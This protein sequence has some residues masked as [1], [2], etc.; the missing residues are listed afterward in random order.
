M[1]QWREVLCLFKNQRAIRKTPA[2]DVPRIRGRIV[3]LAILGMII[4]G[5]QLTLGQKAS[6]SN[7]ASVAEN[8]G[9][10]PLSFETNQGQSGPQV[11]FLSHGVGY[12]VFLT[13]SSATLA[14]TEQDVS[15]AKLDQAPEDGRKS[16]SV[17]KA[18]KIDV[19]QM[20]LAG[21]SHDAHAVGIDQLPGTAN[22]FVGSDPT[23]WHRN[24]PTYSKVKYTDVYPGVDLIYYGNR[25]QLEYDFVIKPGANPQSIRLHFSGL[26]NLKLTPN[27]DLA[28]S[29][30]N[31]EIVFHRPVIYQVKN[32]N[33]QPIEGRFSLLAKQSVGF[34]LGHYDHTKSLVIDPV[35]VY[36]TY[37]GGGASAAAIAVDSA[38]NAYVTG[39]TY[40]ASPNFPTTTGSFQTKSAFGYNAFV[41]KLNSSGTALLYS[42]YLG[43]SSDDSGAGIAVD[44]AGNAY[45]TGVATSRDF[46]V[47]TGAFQP[48]NNGITYETSGS[49]VIYSVPN[50]FITKLDPTGS[51]LIYSTY[52]GGNGVQFPNRLASPPGGT[53]PPYAYQGD[54]ASGIAVDSSGFAYVT[55]Q[56]VSTDFPVTGGAFQTKNNSPGYVAVPGYDTLPTNVF[57][58]KLNQTGTA[59]V[60][61]TY[62]GGTGDADDS[63]GDLGSGIAVDSSDS[64][65]VTGLTASSDYPVTVGAFQITTRNKSGSNA[66]I[67]KLNSMGTALTYSTYLGGSEESVGSSIAVDDSGD[68]Y[69]TGTTE[70]NDFPITPD[71][72]QATKKTSAAGAQYDPP[73]GFVTKLNSTG[74]ELVYST[75][76][77]GSGNVS[78]QAGDTPES[79][80]VDGLGE[81]YLTGTT[82]SIDFPVTAG[83]FQTVNNGATLGYGDTNGFVTKLNPTGA[84]LLY[85][86]Y[87]GGEGVGYNGDSATS[88]AV[89][90]SGNAYVTGLTSSSDFPVTAGAFQATDPC[91]QCTNSFIAKLSLI[92]TTTSPTVTVTPSSSS[93]TAAQGVAATID[94]SGS[95]GGPT[96]T[97]SVTLSSGTYTSAAATLTSGSATIDIPAGSLAIGTDTLTATYTPDSASSSTYNS[98]SGMNTV[99]VTAPLKS[100]PTV[101]VTPSSSSITTAL[102]LTVAVLVSG[103][104]GN[105]TPTGSVTLAGGGYTSAATTLSGGSATI[106]IPAGSLAPAADTL[107]VSYTPDT[108]SSSTYNSATG[109]ASVTVT[110]PP[111]F[112]LSASPTSVSVAQNGSG[113]STISVADLGGFTGTVVLDATG[114]PSGVTA[115]FAAGTAAGTQV[116]TLS[117]S[118]TATLGGPV[119]VTVTGTSGALS[120]TTTV[121]LTVTAE[122]TFGPSGSSGSDGTISVAPGATT[123]NTATI[124]MAGTNGFSGS[125]SLSCSITPMAASDP[126]T[127]SLSPASVTLSGNTAQASTLTV[128]TTAATTAENRTKKLF[129]PSAGGTALALVLLIGV[130]RRRRNWLAIVGLAV[131]VAS[132]SAIGCGG[133]SSVGGGGGGGGNAGTSAG[134]YTVTITGTGTSSGSSSSVTAT[135][136]TVTLTVN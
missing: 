44:S 42:T 21:G 118:S 66:F 97:G 134:T 113:T 40:S 110:V 82:V 127:C 32:G 52:L 56:A 13:D 36:S 74:T 72:F 136:G 15:N 16:I 23:K 130:P 11:K 63:N 39:S 29:A 38:G 131:L 57:V 114:L 54:F 89:D 116:L 119:T 132:I 92:T 101:A 7:C 123:G 51:A 100:T 81:A 31:G 95:S 27:G 70:S 73:T 86:T 124:S 84:A 65:Y 41:T 48:A 126:P 106:N 79:I 83:A 94:V 43:G 122:P 37:F 115:S 14:L 62:I 5:P 91:P 96:P 9:K 93:I 102:P 25:R 3:S 76:L 49:T 120:A 1:S 71:A 59:L 129:W 22:Y 33:R 135:V 61:S 90:G 68:A 64:A 107:T 55:G 109:T 6:I 47:T 12:S 85:S 99:T 10:L 45:V 17:P 128:L 108:S 75:Y 69:V 26:R 78:G 28:L 46:P 60:Y 88:I 8:Y 34:A 133:G 24:L 103:G 50:A 87:L 121:S 80:A 4:G 77:G 125:V 112:T 67:T 18:R 104:S 111:S 117:A 19:V 58:T 98:S 2:A 20:S 53:E 35:L 105:P 30:G